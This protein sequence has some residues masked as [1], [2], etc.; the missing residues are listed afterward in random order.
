VAII[1]GF[2]HEAGREGERQYCGIADEGDTWIIVY[3][4]YSQNN[5]KNKQGIADGA[6][7][8]DED[9]R[10]DGRQR[11]HNVTLAGF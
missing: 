10:G 7:T 6:W 5:R 2:V 9:M 3:F 4:S 11:F 8:N 1:G